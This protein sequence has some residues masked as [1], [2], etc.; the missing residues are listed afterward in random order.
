MIRCCISP[1]KI[2]Q[3]FRILSFG[4]TILDKTENQAFM[5]PQKNQLYDKLGLHNLK[6]LYTPVSLTQHQQ[7]LTL[8]FVGYC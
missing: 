2:D 7:L 4:K 1:Q 5:E 3:N 8:T 6:K